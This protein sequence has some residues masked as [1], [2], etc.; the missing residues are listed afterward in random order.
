MQLSKSNLQITDL[1]TL[2]YGQ[3][4]FHETDI[5]KLTLTMLFTVMLPL[6]LVGTASLTTIT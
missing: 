5:F 3:E 6:E 1:E 2:I 4:G